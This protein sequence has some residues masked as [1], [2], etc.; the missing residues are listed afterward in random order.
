[1]WW[2]CCDSRRDGQSDSHWFLWASGPVHFSSDF[3]SWLSLLIAKFN[4]VVTL[5]PGPVEAIGCMAFQR[6]DG[7]PSQELVGFRPSFLSRFSR[8][9]HRFTFGGG[10]LISSLEFLIECRLV[11]DLSCCFRFG[12]FTL[13]ELCREP[14]PK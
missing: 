14:S 10:D 12:R 3:P 6:T 4:F 2:F 1:G 8:L 9:L 11:C 13:L 7:L 5:L